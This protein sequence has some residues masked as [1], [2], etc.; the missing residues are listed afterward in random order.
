MRAEYCC[1]YDSMTTNRRGAGTHTYTYGQ[2][3][4][5]RMV[6]YHHSRI[7]FTVV[8]G[9][10][11]SRRNIKVK[12][13]RLR[14]SFVL[15]PFANLYLSRQIDIND[16]S[17][18]AFRLQENAELLSTARYTHNLFSALHCVQTSIAFAHIHR[19]RSRDHLQIYLI[20]Y[21]SRWNPNRMVPFTLSLSLYLPISEQITDGHGQ[22]V[23]GF[24][25]FFVLPFRVLFVRS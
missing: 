5:R 6:D 2:L 7:A 21:C 3:Q 12:L 1:F 11:P 8:P 4:V 23:L 10:M 24:R 25:F 20:I 19:G 15:R 16:S 17:I 13:D 9:E 18:I 22:E 14:F